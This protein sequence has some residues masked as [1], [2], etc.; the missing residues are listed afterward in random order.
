MAQQPGQLNA[1]VVFL[2]PEGVAEDW[3][4]TDLWNKAKGIPGVVVINDVDA[5]ES[6]RFNVET[7]GQTVVYSQSG[8]LLFQ[9]GVTASRGHAGDNDG[10]QAI[11]ALLMKGQSRSIQTPVYGCGLFQPSCPEGVACTR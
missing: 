5:S 7:S 2:Q 10:K 3:V 6:R 8:D 1:R 9:G 11:E 4:K